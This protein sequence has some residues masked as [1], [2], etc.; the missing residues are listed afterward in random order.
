MKATYKGIEY[1]L[2]RDTTQTVA[3]S[4]TPPHCIPIHGIA[5]N[6]SGGRAAA[7]KAIRKW[8][9]ENQQNAC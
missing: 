6:Y 2:L 8:R 5:Q 4:I 3:W 1:K 9:L 7:E